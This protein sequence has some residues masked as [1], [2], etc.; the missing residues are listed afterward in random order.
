MLRQ[1]VAR[2][3]WPRGLSATLL[4]ARSPAKA[5]GDMRG[6]L[7]ETQRA[8]L[9]KAEELGQRYAANPATAAVWEHLIGLVKQ[10]R[11]CCCGCARSV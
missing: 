8:S 7:S 1:A 6:S 2:C 3:H 5:N 9:Q 10:V 11:A 4:L